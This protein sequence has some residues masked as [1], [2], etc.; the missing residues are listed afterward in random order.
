MIIREE[1][2]HDYDKVYELIEESFKN[3][4]LS[5]HDE[6]NLVNRLRRSDEFIKELSMIATDHENI[7]G[8][9]MLTKIIILDKEISHDS[10]AL[11][12]VSVLPEYQGKGIGSLLIKTA[13]KKAKELG[14]NSIVV[15]G[16]DKYYPKFGFEKASNYEIIAPF[17]VPDE[18]FMVLELRE[19]S[20]KHVRG[21]V[22]YSKAFFE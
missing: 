10:L 5:D 3:E 6:Q 1:N 16:H 17:E 19:E 13:I 12:P 20:L 21:M 4:K 11:A 22:Q 2:K 9:I 15:L 14:Y 7:V 8:H 18:A